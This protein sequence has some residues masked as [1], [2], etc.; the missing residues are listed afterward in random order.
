ML[1]TEKTNVWAAK[2]ENIF[3]FTNDRSILNLTKHYL[4]DPL[5]NPSTLKAETTNK[6]YKNLI[7]ICNSCYFYNVKKVFERCGSIEI[8]SR[9][10]STLNALKD[11]KICICDKN[12]VNE[13]EFMQQMAMVTYECVIKDS[14]AILPIWIAL[15]KVGL[16]FAID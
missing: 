1:T 2:P 5:T 12:N 10:N 13:R 7:K 4:M 14:L 6:A 16:S 11:Q 8:K 3:A 15:L 9:M